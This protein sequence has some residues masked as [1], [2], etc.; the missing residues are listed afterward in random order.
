MKIIV[1]GCGKVGF[2]I[3]QQLNDEKHDVTVIDSDY[4]R[5]AQ[6]RDDLDVLQITGSGA[7]VEILQ[8]AGIEECDMVIAVTD[9]DELNLLCCMIARKMG[10]CTTIARV[11]NPMYNKEVELLK[12]ALGISMIINPE[13]VAANAIARL[14]RFPG[15]LDI[16]SFSGGKAEQIK[17]EVKSDT[18]IANMSLIDI[19]KRFKIDMLI[20]GVQRGENVSIPNGE[21]VIKPGDKITIVATPE[22]AMLFLDKIGLNTHQ[23]K[24]CIIVGGSNVAVYLA[25]MLKDMNIDVTIIDKSEDKCS[26]LSEIVPHVTIVNGDA[27]DANILRQEGIHKVEAF[28]ALMNMDEENIM[29]SL[30]AAANS[31]AKI[32]TKVDRLNF[33][34]VISSLNLG[35]LISPKNLTAAQ[36][37]RYSRAA[38]NSV[39]SNIETLYR[40]FDNKAEALE[41]IVRNDSSLVNIPLKNLRTKPNTLIASI[42]RNGNIIIPKGDH[43]IFPGDHV[44][45]VT[46]NKHLKD[47]KDILA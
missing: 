23:V 16:E 45:V 29:V 14:L 2:T 33:E 27:S 10:H 32:I 39:G 15:A 40:I 17:I 9:S 22:N 28:V 13:Q 7:S 3:A 11:R 38:L 46:T 25:R 47:L 35:S 37:L 12:E 19:G 26:Y 36:I 8:E 6:I 21:F 41:F 24:D 42:N 31:H 20:T 4:R 18:K 43:R 5:L 1:I 34:D 30:Y 44:I